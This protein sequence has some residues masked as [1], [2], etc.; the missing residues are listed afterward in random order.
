MTPANASRESI[1]SSPIVAATAACCGFRPVANAFGCAR[2]RQPGAVIV[3]IPTTLP[4]LHFV[5]THAGFVAG[6][7]STRLV[8]QLVPQMLAQLKICMVDSNKSLKNKASPRG[9]R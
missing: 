1:S 3:G 5:M 6:N 7:V 9:I 8:D 4:F 2:H